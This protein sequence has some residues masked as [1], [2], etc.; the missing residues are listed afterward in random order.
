MVK[1]GFGDLNF[2]V[3]VKFLTNTLKFGV[4]QTTLHLIVSEKYYFGCS[5]SLLI[6]D[7]L[8]TSP[9]N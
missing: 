5:R 3:L 9:R 7:R 4:D 1:T 2:P 6:V 8:Y